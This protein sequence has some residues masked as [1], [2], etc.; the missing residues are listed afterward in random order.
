MKIFYVNFS[1]MV[2]TV[3]ERG[4]KREREIIKL[5]MLNVINFAFHEPSWLLVM[6]MS[7]YIEQNF[8]FFNLL[9]VFFILHYIL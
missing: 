2:Q 3:I 6:T 4:R 8:L 1:L 5:K 7:F 9:K